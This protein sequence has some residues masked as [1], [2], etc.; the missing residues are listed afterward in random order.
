M[1]NP[2]PRQK[3]VTTG[4]DNKKIILVKIR[5]HLQKLIISQIRLF[6][7]WIITEYPLLSIVVNSINRKTVTPSQRGRNKTPL[8]LTMKYCDMT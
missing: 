1:N 6:L 7:I 4:H 2:I 3:W 5:N 8:S